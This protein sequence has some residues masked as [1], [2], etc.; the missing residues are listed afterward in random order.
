[1]HRREF[2]AGGLATLCLTW[3]AFA[4]TEPLVNPQLLVAATSPG[5]LLV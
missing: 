5:L 3:T 2:I 1:M 4:V